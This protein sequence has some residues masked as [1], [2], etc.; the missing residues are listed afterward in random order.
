MTSMLRN[1]LLSLRDAA[2]TAGPFLLLGLLLVAVAYWWLDPTPP[3]RVTLATG[4]PQGAYA[5]FGRR[6]AALLEQHGVKVELRN[7][8]GAAEN[9]ALLRDEHSAVDIGFAQGGAP[10]AADDGLVSLGSMFHEPLWLFYREDSAR[11]LLG[12]RAPGTGA[13]HAATAAPRGR[14]A[15]ATLESLAQLAGW[16]LNV[17]AAG[18]GVPPL[19]DRLL[20]AN[21]LAPGAVELSRLTLTPAVMALLDGRIDALVMAS[22]P[23]SLMVRMLLQTPG[24]R[25]ASFAQAEAYARRFPF[26]SHV[27]LPRGVADLAADIPPQD[28]HLLAPTATLVA[29]PSLHPALMQLFMQAAQQ[30]H[31]SAGWFQRKG[32]F[33]TPANAER[34]IAPEAQRFFREGTPWLQRYLP[35]WLAN[36][37]DRMWIVLVAIIAVLLPLSRVIP[38]LYQFR[39]RSRVFRWYGQLRAVEEASAERP[40]AELLRELEDIEARVGRVHIPLSYA[41]ELYALRSHIQMVR[42]RLQDSAR[43]PAAAGAGLEAA[44]P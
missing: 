35:F 19:M 2:V 16:K 39:V 1:T 15:A 41:D 38:P 29:R 44:M 8:Q 43:L 40:A 37:L 4:V 28:V 6:Y 27:V 10:D 32:E 42:R 13:A 12:A 18:S 14:G 21:H 36:L 22:A 26:M 7:T 9:A 31:G 33:P 24:V 34:P 3:R 11:R 20:E 5:E 17:G 23:E 30:V 25:L